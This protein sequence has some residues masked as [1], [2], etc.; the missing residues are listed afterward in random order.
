[1]S[2]IKSAEDEREHELKRQNFE[3]GRF[4]IHGSPHVSQGVFV[5]VDTEDRDD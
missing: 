5:R 4:F 1:V 3:V 2:R